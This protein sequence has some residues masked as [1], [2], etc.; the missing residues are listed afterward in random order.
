MYCRVVQA[1]MLLIRDKRKFFFFCFF[2]FDREICVTFRKKRRL[3][4]LVLY[5]FYLL[6]WCFKFRYV[7]KYQI[8]NEKKN[9]RTIYMLLL[10]LCDK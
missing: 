8:E 3:L 10:L 6:H 2:R 5:V 1:Y 4:P 7:L 9:E